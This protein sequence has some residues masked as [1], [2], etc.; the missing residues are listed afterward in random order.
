MSSF[1]VAIRIFSVNAETDPDLLKP[2]KDPRAIL[3]KETHLIYLESG[4]CAVEVTFYQEIDNLNLDNAFA[5]QSEGLEK[6]EEIYLPESV[7]ADLSKKKRKFCQKFTIDS[8]GAEFTYGPKNF[9]IILSISKSMNH[10]ISRQGSIIKMETILPDGEE[11][12]GFKLQ[13]PR[14]MSLNKILVFSG[15]S[16]FNLESENGKNQDENPAVCSSSENGKEQDTEENQDENPAVCSSS[17]NGKEQDT[18]ENQDENPA[19]C[20][21]SENGKEQDTEEKQDENPAVCSLSEN[22]KE[23]DTEEKQDENPAVC[24]SSEN[25]KEQD[26]E[27]N[28]DENPAVCSSS[29][30]GKEQDTEENQDENPAVCSSNPEDLECSDAQFAASDQSDVLQYIVYDD[31]YFCNICNRKCQGIPD[32]LGHTKLVTRKFKAL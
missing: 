29:E 28:Q 19:V 6:A 23:Q 15:N 3:H 16:D 4:F 5:A 8:W 17:E 9:H 12:E 18:E 24:S 25:G 11:S 31:L 20:S 14:K 2:R 32:L 13:I 10:F 21:S 26:T 7:I 27:E 1:H 22:G 30:N